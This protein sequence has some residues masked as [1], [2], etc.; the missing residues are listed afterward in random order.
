MQPSP[1][2]EIQINNRNSTINTFATTPLPFVSLMSSELTN[3]NNSNMHFHTGLHV[4]RN[5]VCVVKFHVSSKHMLE[6]FSR[7]GARANHSC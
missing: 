6:T 4:R 7:S 1:E 2:L 5:L 3:K